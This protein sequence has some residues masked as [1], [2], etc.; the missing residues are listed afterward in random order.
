MVSSLLLFAIKDVW[1]SFRLLF[2]RNF[3]SFV[4]SIT[5][6]RQHADPL[7]AHFQGQPHGRVVKCINLRLWMEM[8]THLVRVVEQF[9]I[10]VS[11]EIVSLDIRKT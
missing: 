2:L 4:V 1:L 7:S 10:G 3:D 5:Y 11:F 9:M 8:P 6:H